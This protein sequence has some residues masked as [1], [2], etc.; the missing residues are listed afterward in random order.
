MTFTINSRDKK[1]VDINILYLTLMREMLINAVPLATAMEEETMISLQGEGPYLCYLAELLDYA[2]LAPEGRTITWELGQELRPEPRSPVPSPVSLFA[3]QGNVELGVT[4]VST[5]SDYME[6]RSPTVEVASYHR[7]RS[8]PT[9]SRQRPVRSQP[10]GEES[11]DYSGT[12]YDTYRST[13]S[14]M[15]QEGEVLQV[16]GERLRH[17]VS[18]VDSMNA[19]LDR[20]L[21]RIRDIEGRSAS[22]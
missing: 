13:A 11:P 14:D 16:I 2:Q 20:C 12:F 19:E 5:A 6:V 9:H 1:I 18:R 22:E 3:D 21:E 8:V 7:D 17:A 4:M 15:E 10:T